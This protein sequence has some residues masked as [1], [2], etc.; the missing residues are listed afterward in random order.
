MSNGNG[1]VRAPSLSV[2]VPVLN[3]TRNSP[4]R[5][6]PTRRI[7]IVQGYMAGVKKAFACTVGGCFN[8]QAKA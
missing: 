1:N 5:R 2:P 3:L 8:S 7:Y 4:G 6:V